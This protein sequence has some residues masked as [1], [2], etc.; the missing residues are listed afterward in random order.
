MLVLLGILIFVYNFGLGLHYASGLEPSLTVEFLYNYGFLCGVVWW[1]RAEGRKYN[2]SKLY[3]DG[4]LVGF[5]WPFLVP[6]HLFKT[7]G[8][9]GFIPLLGLIG[10]FVAAYVLTVIIYLV[11]M[12]DLR[13]N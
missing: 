4:L 5:G 11:L 2:L 9:K 10:S 6:Y 3:C 1:L 7:R 13:A 8:V 12:N